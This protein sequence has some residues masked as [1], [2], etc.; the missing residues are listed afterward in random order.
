MNDHAFR[1]FILVMLPIMLMISVLWYSFY[2]HTRRTIHTRLSRVE[3]MR[4]I[5]KNEAVQGNIR[6]VV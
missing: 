2:R 3:G 4:V 6:G 5:E 1:L